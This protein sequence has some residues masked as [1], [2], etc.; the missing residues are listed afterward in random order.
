MSLC[1]A[2]YREHVEKASIFFSLNNK[3]YNFNLFRIY[4]IIIIIYKIIIIIIIIFGSK[5]LL[6]NLFIPIEIICR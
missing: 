4:K 1:I 2:G 3:A 5:V 6:V